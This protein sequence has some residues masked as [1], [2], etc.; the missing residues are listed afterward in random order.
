MGAVAA[1]AVKIFAVRHE[2][3]DRYELVLLRASITHE[4]CIPVFRWRGLRRCRSDK[5]GRRAASRVVEPGTVPRKMPDQ[6]H[7]AEV[8]VVP[9]CRRPTT[10]NNPVAAD[11]RRA[12]Q[13]HR[14]SCGAASPVS[15]R[16]RLH[17]GRPHWLDLR[18]GRV[19]D[20]ER[21]DHRLF[22]PAR[23]SAGTQAC[24]VIDAEAVRAGAGRVVEADLLGSP[25]SR[26]RR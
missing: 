26:C 6:F 16:P 15:H 9:R 7:V 24:A 18:L 10:R 2:G 8:E 1:G 13:R 11:H 22:S 17:P 21:P 5:A 25:P 19:L 23:C 14:L 3:R 4:L 12:V 20:V